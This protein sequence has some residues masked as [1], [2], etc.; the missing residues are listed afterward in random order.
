MKY[1]ILKVIEPYKLDYHKFLDGIEK[2][3]RNIEEMYNPKFGVKILA[4]AAPSCYSDIIAKKERFDICLGTKF[5]IKLYNTDYE[6]KG[7]VKK[8]N[9]FQYLK[10]VGGQH[11][12]TLVTDHLD[13]LPLINMAINNIIYNPTQFMKEELST[14]AIPYKSRI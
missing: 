8:K 10:S 3:K 14:N 6:N 4:T 9:V 12:D 13:D 1:I 2:Y 7:E 11:I 5:P